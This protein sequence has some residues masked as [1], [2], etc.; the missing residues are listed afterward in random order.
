MNRHSQEVQGAWLVDFIDHVLKKGLTRV[1]PTVEAEEGWGEL[2]QG[3]FSASLMGQYSKN[4]TAD[5][6]VERTPAYLGGL[7][8]FIQKYSQVAEG[9]YEGFV[10]V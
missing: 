4:F 5:G 7:A 9:G 6:Q 2:A 10:L 8:T 3:L 1:E